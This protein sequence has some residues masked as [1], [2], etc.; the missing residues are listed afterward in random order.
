MVSNFDILQFQQLSSNKTK[1][2]I[3]EISKSKRNITLDLFI[4]QRNHFFFSC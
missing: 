1:N 3:K 4:F 2:P